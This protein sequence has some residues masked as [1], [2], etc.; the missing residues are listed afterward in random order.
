MLLA[1]LEH[2]RAGNQSSRTRKILHLRCDNC[3][4]EFK[5]RWQ[6]EITEQVTHGCSR[7]CAGIIAS[8]KIDVHE[9]IRVL[10]KKRMSEPDV[11]E[12]LKD[13]IKRREENPVYRKNLRD[14]IKRSFISNPER[15]QNIAKRV[16]AMFA[17]PE[18]R[19][20]F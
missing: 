9:K 5:R 12:R 17:D 7:K 16:K 20:S 10:V 6:R 4:N 2:P 18:F 8:K 13:G 11:R 15:A 1:I 19:N 3:G 14:G